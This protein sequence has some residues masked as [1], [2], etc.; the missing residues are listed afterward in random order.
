[1][2]KHLKSK[3]YTGSWRVS[4]LLCL[5]ELLYWNLVQPLF[6]AERSKVKKQITADVSKIKESG[7]TNI[8]FDA[9]L[10]NVIAFVRM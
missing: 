2:L 6:H 3:N 10:K 1:M 8:T 7:Q 5:V 9:L 4:L